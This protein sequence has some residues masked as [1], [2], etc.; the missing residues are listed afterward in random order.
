VL[1]LVR[2]VSPAA[3]K[4]TMST[5]EHTHAHISPAGR[6]Q[7]R[8]APIFLVI[9]SGQWSAANQVSMVGPALARFSIPHALVISV[10][11]ML[12][13]KWKECVREGTVSNQRPEKSETRPASERARSPKQMCRCAGVRECKCV[14]ACVCA[15]VRAGW[16]GY[17]VSVG[18]GG[19]AGRRRS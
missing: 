15:L 10:C 9:V 1:N 12:A 2:E 16:G 18:R 11:T 13:T 3:N 5:Y 6:V 17:R 7:K 4:A 14:G 8:H 19:R